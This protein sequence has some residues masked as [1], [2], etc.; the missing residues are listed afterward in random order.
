MILKRRSH[1]TTGILVAGATLVMAAG[2]L[3]VAMATTGGATIVSPPKVYYLALGDSLGAGYQP[4]FTTACPVPPIT[5]CTTQGY[6]NDLYKVY[7]KSIND[8]SNVLKLENLSCP[9]ESSATMISGG[10]CTYATKT[11]PSLTNQLQAAE[12]FIANNPVAFVTID[13]GANDVDGCAGYVTHNPPDPNYAA[14]VPACVLSG[15]TNA[16]YGVNADGIAGIDTNMPTILAGLQNAIATST[17]SQ[18]ARIYGMNYY[19]PFLALY[20]EAAY[21]GPSGFAEQSTALAGQLN[22]H[23]AADYAAASPPIPVADVAGRFQTDDASFHAASYTPVLD[24]LFTSPLL[25][26]NVQDICAW[27]WECTTQENIHANATGYA[28]MAVA[29]EQVMGYLP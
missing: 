5:G 16:T 4:T 29:F 28:A 8:A 12:T 26:N 10:I 24:L 15:A 11:N 17:K 19:D 7:K 21:T 13:M 2:A 6:V 14:D 23:L 3:S 18:G 9:G 22:S 27:T 1:R 20:L 25:P